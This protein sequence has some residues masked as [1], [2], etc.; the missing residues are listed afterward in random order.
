MQGA[1]FLDVFC[2]FCITHDMLA[3]TGTKITLKPSAEQALFLRKI[4][5]AQRWLWNH[6]LHKNILH[7][8]R[9]P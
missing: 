2:V 7:Q 8:R 5:G 6:F 1:I 3:L 4:L 9:T